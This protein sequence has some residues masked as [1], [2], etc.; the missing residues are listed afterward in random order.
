MATKLPKVQRTGERRPA[1]VVVLIITA[2]LLLGVVGVMIYSG[3]LFD[4]EPK[5]DAERDYIVLLEG[6]KREPK[7][8]AV[9]MTLAEAEYKL[10]KKSDAFTHADAA[11]VA[12]EKKPGYRVRYAGILVQDGQLEKARKLVQDEIALKTKD[13]AEPFFLLA[14]IEQ[15]LGNS[16]AAQ[17]AMK[18]GLAIAP[19]AADMIIVYGRILEEAGD[20]ASAITQ[21]TSALRFLPDSQQ[22]KDGLK[23]LGAKIPSSQ[24]A[25]SPHGGAPQ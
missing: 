12:A 22:A 9:L 15:A 20:K 19:T 17:E 7:N 13:D 2:L 11:I 8:P 5:T 1:L 21:Y 18:K 14:Q 10:N 24:D 25:T 4:E 23:R 3:G 6:V 16:K